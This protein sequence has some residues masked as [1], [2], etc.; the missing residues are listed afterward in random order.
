MEVNVVVTLWGSPFQAAAGF[1]P[2]AGRFREPVGP[3]YAL[4]VFDRND[5]FQQIGNRRQPGTNA[6]GK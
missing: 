3:G 4:N 5:L 2:G 6:P 1:R